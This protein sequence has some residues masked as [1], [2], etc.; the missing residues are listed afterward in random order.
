MK[1]LSSD[2]YQKYRKYQQFLKE[3]P[4]NHNL[5]SFYYEKIIDVVITQCRIYTDSTASD[6]ETASKEKT[7]H[8]I[9]CEFVFKDPSTSKEVSKFIGFERRPIDV[10]DNQWRISYLYVDPQNIYDPQNF[11]N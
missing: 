2:L 6:I 5:N 11:I 7:W 8:Q 9:K 10:L 1:I 3:N 4:E